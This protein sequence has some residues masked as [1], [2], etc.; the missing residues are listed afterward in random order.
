[1]GLAYDDPAPS[2]AKAGTYSVKGD[3]VRLRSE[4]STSG[5]ILATLSK[6]STVTSSGRRKAGS[7]LYW[8]QVKDNAS[9][10]TGWMAEQYLVYIRNPEQHRQEMNE[11]RIDA[12]TTPTASTSLAPD[13]APPSSHHQN[14]NG[15]TPVAYIQGLEVKAPNFGYGLLEVTQD[16]YS[17]TKYELYVPQRVNGDNSNPL[18]EGYARTPES[19][20]TTFAIVNWG[21]VLANI[22]LEGGSN[23]NRNI[24]YKDS[25]KAS[26]L[27]TIAA[28]TLAIKDAT[29]QFQLSVTFSK[30]GDQLGATVELSTNVA[31]LQT[32][33]G[34][35]MMLIDCYNNPYGETYL[36]IALTDEKKAIPIWAK[37]LNVRMDVDIHRAAYWNF[38]FY[39]Y[40]D[41]N[42]EWFGL[43][44]K[45]AGDQFTLME[46][47]FKPW[48]ILNVYTDYDL[49]PF[50]GELK[51]D[52]DFDG[53]FNAVKV[54]KVL[55]D[56]VE[57]VLRSRLHATMR[58]RR[59]N[60]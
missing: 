21:A 13:T 24:T 36:G 22:E 14:Q 1:M 35:Y 29:M 37:E 9:G 16:D 44:K 34:S 15:Y 6:Y 3:G 20:T 53:L 5:R 17:V 55:Q 45:Y 33:A 43:P 26:L 49:V 48:N 58:A 57:G 46:R 28:T 52:V 39:L 12:A 38:S 50:E 11:K 2:N 42:G 4:P 54:D 18:P 8:L 10:K 60:E 23:T 40:I 59:N 7:G 56:K 51:V 32:Y 25:A 31:R 30:N 27:G 19:F 41:K 47:H